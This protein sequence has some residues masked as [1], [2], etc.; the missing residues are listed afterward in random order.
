PDVGD[1]ALLATLDEWLAPML[2]SATSRADLARVDPGALL[3]ARLDHRARRHLDRLA[4]A[5]LTLPSG[6]Q[7]RLDYAEAAPVLAVA[8][9]ELF[10]SDRHPSVLD[11]EVPVVLHLLS[12]AGRPVQITSD[13]AGFW[14][15][16]WAEVRREMAGRYPKHP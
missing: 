3:V 5:T 11:G 16:T 6:R 1:R 13:L 10:G 8:P 12:P 2:P 9:Q 14:S 15:G 7:V 4:P